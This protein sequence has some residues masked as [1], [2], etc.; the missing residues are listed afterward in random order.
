MYFGD[1]DEDAAIVNQCA[2]AMEYLSNHPSR[3]VVHPHRHRGEELVRDML[4]T[5]TNDRMCR[6]VCR[7]NKHTFVE[8]CRQARASGLED[9]RGASVE[10][11][12][13][14]FCQLMGH[15]T[16]VRKLGHEFSHSEETIHRYVYK[17]FTTLEQWFH[18]RISTMVPLEHMPSYIRNNR[19]FYPY[20]KDCVGA[21]DG[22]HV[23]AKVKS[24]VSNAYRGKQ[25]VTTQNVMC[26]CDFSMRFTYVVTGWEGSAHDQRILDSVLEDENSTFP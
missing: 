22:T 19:K 26:V 20:F 11:Q 13:M 8:L 23:M 10:E 9:S 6:D 18:A 4:Y 5:V 25:K 21:I 14:I 16:S 3:N 2:I 12:L 15:G 24:D 17:V 7:M 1:D